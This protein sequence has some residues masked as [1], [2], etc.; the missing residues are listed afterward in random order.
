MDQSAE[1][2]SRVLFWF[3]K[4]SQ[5]PRASFNEKQISDFLVA[6]AKER[7]I[8]YIQDKLYNIIL[9]KEASAG[10]ESEEPLILQGH[11]DM[12]CEKL[13][14]AEHDFAKDPLKLIKDGDHITAD[15]TTLGADDGIGVAMILALFE[16]EELLHPRLEAVITVSEETGMEGAI[17]LSTAPLKG[18]RLLNLDS[19]DEGVLL[20]SC[21]GGSTGMLSLIVEWE[22]RKGVP[23]KIKLGGLLGGHS[24]QEID[25]ER[26]NASLLLG[27]LLYALKKRLPFALHALQGGTK[28]NAIPREAEATLFI[29][30]GMETTF[31]SAIKVQERI[32]RNEFA[33]SDPGIVIEAD[34]NP[35]GAK[36][37]ALCVTDD[38]L[39]QILTLLTLLPNG[40]QSMSTDVSGLVKTSLNLG[41]MK[42]EGR[43]LTLETLL[44][45]SVESEKD[46]LENKLTALMSLFRGRIE[47]SSPYPAWEWKQNSPMRNA[48]IE[49][50]KEQYEGKEPKVEAI[51]AGVECGIFAG[52][53]D[54]LDAVS[55]GP[56]IADIHTT[57]ETLSISSTERVYRYVR[58]FVERK[59]QK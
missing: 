7:G 33:S 56:D 45:S 52:K 36:K 57:E 38:S 47:F 14:E 10:Y 25:K 2:S 22:Q 32:F 21:A 34:L 49:L 19:E 15:G 31:L 54:G 16:D 27:R 51:H 35:D 5:I 4:I 46:A 9:I 58:A 40:V 6:F 28:A 55:I 1:N 43:A 3:E 39:R 50:Y 8:N 44:R 18:K 41:I 11:M 20:C 29:P 17:G 42:L 30:E 23:I 12:V 59:K 13:P 48:L 26:G 37:E 53:I 24:G